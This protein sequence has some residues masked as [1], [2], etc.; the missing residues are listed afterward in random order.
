MQRIDPRQLEEDGNVRD[1]LTSIDERAASVRQVSMPTRCRPGG[2]PAPSSS[3]SAPERST[4]VSARRVKIHPPEELRITKQRV[5]QIESWA[6]DKLRE[7]RKEPGSPKSCSVQKKFA[8]LANLRKAATYCRPSETIFG[9]GCGQ[10]RNVHGAFAGRKQGE[11]QR[12]KPDS[13]SRLS[14]RS[15]CLAARMSAVVRWPGRRP[16]AGDAAGGRFPKISRDP[17]R[18]GFRQEQDG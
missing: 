1:K 12:S 5:R 8:I 7:P 17:R 16:E 18:S 9:D 6:G 10:K 15:L 14:A 13:L 2:F 3:P 11:G 4:G